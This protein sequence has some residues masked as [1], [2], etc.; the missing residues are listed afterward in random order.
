MRS[1]GG[2]QS[3]EDAGGFMLGGSTINGSR[4]ALLAK[5]YRNYGVQPHSYALQHYMVIAQPNSKGL[6]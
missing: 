2:Y 6:E 1:S 3:A 4:R 5:P